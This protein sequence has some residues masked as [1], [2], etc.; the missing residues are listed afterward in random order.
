MPVVLLSYYCALI[1][2]ASLVG[3]M[4]PVWVHLTHRRMQFAVSFVA[5]AMLGV[6]VL[7]MLPHAISEAGITP[8]LNDPAPLAGIMLWLLAGILVMFFME[9][10]FCF[11]HHDAPD[12]YGEAGQ[13]Q[14]AAPVGSDA[15][16]G[17]HR[18]DA[19][20]GV[21]RDEGVHGLSG[22]DVLH[23]LSWSGAALGLALHSVINGIA[24][25]AA[26]EHGDHGAGL[27]GFGTFL[28]ILLHKPFDAVTIGMLMA[29]SR[30]S[31]TWRLTVNALFPLAVPLGA[32]VFYL[33]L[34]QGGSIALANA[35][36]FAAGTF[37]CI[38][39]SDLLPELQFHQHDRVKLSLALVLGL[40]VAYAAGRLEAAT[41]RDHASNA[42]RSAAAPA[43]AMRKSQSRATAA[44][45][46]L[47]VCHGC[48]IVAS[49]VSIEFPPCPA[50]C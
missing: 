44:R 31:L 20:C 30:C 49:G 40:A 17:Q 12:Q 37:L 2:A 41:H 13:E 47:T 23:D 11:H 6:G 27:A 32:G 4:I 48:P 33:G 14:P 8:G 25:A 36:A 46:T 28:V 18:H 35:L 16:T 1:L 21:H 7:Q 42:A 26:V 34:H 22:R 50:R 43:A 45:T 38:S 15:A 29:R 39:L 9:R 24:L 5:G 3:G 10:F 19:S